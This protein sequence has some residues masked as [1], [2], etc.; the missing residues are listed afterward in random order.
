M[1]LG[2]F[3]GAI[4]FS[5]FAFSIPS[6]SEPYCPQDNSWRISTDETLENLRETS[7]SQKLNYDNLKILVW[8]VY[9]GGKLGVYTDLDSLTQKTDLALLQEGHLSGAFL[10]LVCSREDLNWKMARNYVDSKGIHAGVVTASRENPDSF[11][12]LKSPNTESFSDVHKVSLISYYAIPDRDEKLMVVNV[13]GIN[14]V[15]QEYYENQ[16]NSIAEVIKKHNGPVICAGDFNTY[17]DARRQFLVKTITSLGLTHAKVDGNEYEGLVV[18]D[19]L[20][21]RG[22]EVTKTEVL[23]YVKTSDHTPLYFELRL[24]K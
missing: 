14:F 1:K 4:F 8:N 6:H 9:K 7:S 12:Y 13:H 5:L 24:S 10:N 21:Y 20:F 19:H 11:T 22:F 23:S 15:T 17:T 3:L 2:I 16:I 18:L